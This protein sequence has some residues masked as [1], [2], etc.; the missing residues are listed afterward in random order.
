MEYGNR[1]P[2]IFEV[3]MKRVYI[4]EE[5]CMGCGLCE[6]YCRLE[7]AASKDMLKALKK[8]SSHSVSRVAVQRKAPVSFAL[9]CRHCD[10]PYCVYAC[11]TG[12][13]QRD[14]ESGTVLV[15]TDKCMGCWTCVLSCP[16]GV[17]RRDIER[18]TIAKCDLCYAS[19]TPACVAHCPNEALVYTETETPVSAS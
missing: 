15:D 3:D 8:D 1:F 9:Q 13:L 10:E 19:G 18:G 6:V 14:P 2:P 5:A 17:I 11:L 12:A 4:K 16:F 7:H